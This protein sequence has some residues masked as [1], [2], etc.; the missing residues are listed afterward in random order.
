MTRNLQ[1]EVNVIDAKGDTI[2]TIFYGRLERILDF[3]VPD[4]ACFG[5]FRGTRR[6]LAVITP[7][8]TNG[9]DATN[10]LT[11]YTRTTTEIVTDLQAIEAVVG[12]VYSRKTWWIVDR[13]DG[14]ARVVFATGE[15]DGDEEEENS[16]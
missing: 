15:E 14:M 4:N 13:T 5:T 11:G 2:R 10:Q 3:D 7:C 16:N 9:K 8:V 12:R 1:Y 6:L